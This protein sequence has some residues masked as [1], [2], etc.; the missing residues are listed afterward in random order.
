MLKF[1]RNYKIDFEIQGREKLTIGFPLTLQFSLS[2]NTFSQINTFTGTLYGLN[3]TSRA[4]LYRDLYD[5]SRDIK[6]NLYAGYEN[7]MPLIFRGDFKECYSYQG[8]GETEYKTEIEAFDGGMAM[9]LSRSNITFAKGTDS[10]VVI[11]SLINDLKEIDSAT[12]SPQIRIP[13]TSRG[14]SFVGKTYDLLDEY[15]GGN[16]YVDN[17]HLYILERNDVLKGDLMVIN[18]DTGLLS[19]PRRRE[20]VLEI[21][22]TFEP[23]LI[24]GQQLELES[25]IPEYNGIYKVIGITHEG[26]ISGAE[27]GKLTTKAQLFIGE[28]IFRMVAR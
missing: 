8:S 20:Q 25:K 15:V 4:L 26:I 3:K 9:Y 18:A 12:I 1:N 2:R 7:D 27:N 23:R 13:A 28:K 14:S 21:E 24:V 22:M 10:N 6:I 5:M 19:T 17:G 11:N 16:M